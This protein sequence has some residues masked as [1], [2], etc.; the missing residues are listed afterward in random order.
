M[1]KKLYLAAVAATLLTAGSLAPAHA[2]L[3]GSTYDAS[4]SQTGS[5]AIL[6]A[7]EPGPYTVDTGFPGF[8]IGPASNS[9]STSGMAGAAEVTD[10]QVLLSFAGS[11]DSSSGTFTLVLDNFSKPITG[12][13]YVSGSL[14]A[15]S[16]TSFSST[17]NSM[18]F[19]FD[20][21]ADGVFAALGG[22]EI[23]FNVASAPEPASMAL[24]GAGLAG[25][26]VIRRRR[27]GRAG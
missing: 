2:G 14:E 3:L 27:A 21:T 18:T 6:A 25:L 13:S 7:P 19:V 5:V 8:C 12:L 10:Q 11:T 16:L 24:L 15:G 23:V 17:S 26:G 1:V 22:R 4:M 20:D 9:C